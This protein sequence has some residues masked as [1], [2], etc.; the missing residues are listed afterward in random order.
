MMDGFGGRG[1]GWEGRKK[2]SGKEEGVVGWERNLKGGKNPYLVHTH[3]HTRTH[4]CT[5]TRT[6]FPFVVF[7]PFLLEDDHFGSFSVFSDSRFDTNKFITTMQSASPDDT[8]DVHTHACDMYLKRGFPIKVMSS[9][10]AN[11][12]CR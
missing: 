6:M 3:T 2:G 1:R 12:T 5:H 11:N 9:E 4:A 7:S 10:P 8:C